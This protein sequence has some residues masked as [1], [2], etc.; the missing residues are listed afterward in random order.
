MPADG[1]K[2]VAR[3]D[4]MKI[5]RRNFDWR[6]EEMAPLIA[7]SRI[8]ITT[9]NLGGEK[10]SD[11]VYDSTMMQAA[12]MMAMFIAGHIINPGQRWVKLKHKDDAANEM[13]AIREWNEEC[14]DRLLNWLNPGKFYAEAPET[15]LD[16]CGFGTGFLMAEEAPQPTNRTIQGFRGFYIHA[17]RIGRYV[18]AEGADGLVDTVGYEFEMSA[19]VVAAMYP[20]SA[21]ESTKTAAAKQPDKPIKIVHFIQPRPTA[22][23]GYGRK[24]TEMPWQSCWIEHE[25]KTVL[26]ESG[27]R[28]FPAAVPRYQKTPNEV[29]GRGRGD[30]AFPDASTLNTAKRMGLED[31]ALKIRPPVMMRNDSVIGTLKLTPGG[32]SRIN[33][34]GQPLRDVIMPWQTGSHPEVSNIKEEE[35]R[36]TIREIFFVDTIR[37]LLETHKSEM[38]A[39]EFAKKMELLF[40]IIGP[41]YGP[42]EYEFLYKI[43]DVFWD[44]LYH[45]KVF[46]P[47]PPEMAQFGGDLDIQFVNPISLAQKSGDAET[48]LMWM[49]DVSPMAQLKPEMLDWIDPDKS[50]LGLAMVRGL[51]AKWTRSQAQVDALR[52]ERFKQDQA[53]QQMEQIGAGAQAAGQVAPLVKALSEKTQAGQAA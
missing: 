18:I 12:E 21:S 13:D 39:L 50:A 23:Q 1:H 11:G 47:P 34:H 52:K 4:Q 40:R 42:M 43:V 30:I 9:R 46:S 38:T 41:V 49:N 51:P 28:V 16:Y 44:L 2:I 8:G 45:A 3:Y 27:Y 14:T 5:D 31:W 17:T 37:Q 7:P 26:K 36:R 20:D 53:Q 22:E 35:L 29:Y 32:P 6:W 48:F 10:Q 24:A 15:L 33:T 19:R 25:S